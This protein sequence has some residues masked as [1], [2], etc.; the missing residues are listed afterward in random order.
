MYGHVM[1]KD[2]GVAIKRVLEVEIFGVATID[3]SPEVPITPTS[4]SSLRYWYGVSG[5]IE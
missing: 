5:D 2:M 3:Q 1:K 4:N